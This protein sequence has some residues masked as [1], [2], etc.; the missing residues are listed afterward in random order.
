MKIKLIAFLIIL[1]PLVGLNAQPFT[2]FWEIMEVTVGSEKLTPVAKWTRINEDRTFQ[3]GNGWLQNAAG[4]W[5]YDA[6]DSLFSA[7]DSLGIK[8]EYGP[9]KVRFEGK[10]MYWTR[11]EEGVPVV[12]H[13][14]RI[15]R[16]PMSTAD[17]LQ[18][19]WDLAAVRE[20]EVD[21][22]T[23]FDPLEKYYL[24][25]RWDRIY[26]ERDSKGNRS[27]GYW[28]IH[29]HRPEVTFLSHREGDEPGGWHV[30]VNGRRLSLSGISDINRGMEMVFER[31]N[32]F[33]E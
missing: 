18:G 13:L 29:G 22:T 21:I 17:K 2:G 10:V 9:F 12:V 19:L 14:K 15:S 3:S 23:S 20:G 16:M 32:E 6:R 11:I 26:V 24:F 27:T 4:T 33:P 1:V 5:T 25:I 28:H 31:I 30:T 7:E 8:D